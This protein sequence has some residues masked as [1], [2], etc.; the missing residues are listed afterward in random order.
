MKLESLT[1]PMVTGALLGSESQ[2]ES[3]NGSPLHD[4]YFSL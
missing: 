1:K 3:V 4:R 2:S